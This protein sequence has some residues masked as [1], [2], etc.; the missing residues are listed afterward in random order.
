MHNPRQPRTHA[1]PHAPLHPPPQPQP[2]PHPHQ[3]LPQWAYT[4]T[5]DDYHAYEPHD[6]PCAP[7][8]PSDP[9]GPAAT[10][11]EPSPILEHPEHTSSPA[12]LDPAPS[13][14]SA[15]APLPTLRVQRADTLPPLP[16]EATISAV[17]TAVRLPESGPGTP[18]SAAPPPILAPTPAV[19][20]PAMPAMSASAP[21]TS[22][23]PV[24][25]AAGPSQPRQATSSSD[26]SPTE[27]HIL[28]QRPPGQ[29]PPR[30]N[31]RRAVSNVAHAA[32]A[33]DPIAYPARTLSYHSAAGRHR[34]I[35]QDRPERPASAGVP[36]GMGPDP[37]PGLSRRSTLD[38]VVP[39]AD[40]ERDVR[41]RDS[42]MGMSFMSARENTVSERL[43]P[44]LEHAMAARAAAKR[45][46][47]YSGY[48]LNICIGIQVVLGAIT[49]GVA[50]ASTTSRTSTSVG[51]PI[52]GGLSTLA[53]SYL[54][55]S[56]GSGEPEK[57]VVRA[58]DLE[59][60]IRDAEAFLLDRGHL[61]GPQY[62]AEVRR[63]R[64]RF[65]E[66]MG[67]VS[68]KNGVEPQAQAQG[69][70]EKDVE[71][72]GAP[73]VAP[74]MGP[75]H[76]GAMAQ[77]LQA[78]ASPGMVAGAA[79]HSPM[80]QVHP[81]AQGSA[82]AGYFAQG[83]QAGP[84]TGY[85]SQM[86]AVPLPPAAQMVHVGQV[87]PMA[88]GYAGAGGQREM[89]KYFLGKTTLYRFRKSL[90]RQTYCSFVGFHS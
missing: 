39:P 43:K 58:H 30:L 56:R 17:P 41:D 10:M 44:T 28:L 20:R 15:P 71:A 8:T 67:H 78:R 1:H 59:H 81:L 48:A 83:A 57:S 11:P 73:G 69:R 18:S 35:R 9:A 55:R 89:A 24:P 86:A 29:T 27:E 37:Y 90:Q 14:N 52:L 54:A 74:M 68:G 12:P 53:A 72:G 63:Y 82:A 13:Q 46:A 23:T 65:E 84:T 21:T 45:K 33:S 36:T 4:H 75:A 85:V 70:A 40:R 16:A 87:G 38:Y 19:P 3:P 25:P 61:I 6:Y 79:Q 49:T 77:Q 32:I 26:E 5:H 76:L 51:I 7:V 80:A 22:A 2:Q 62:D 88:M 31:H 66:I 50:A 42:K 47:K 34:S 64:T 60:F